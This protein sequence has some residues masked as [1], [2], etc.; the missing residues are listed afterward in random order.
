MKKIYTKQIQAAMWA[1]GLPCTDATY[2]NIMRS[3]LKSGMTEPQAFALTKQAFAAA[4][5]YT[6]EL[7]VGSL[8][9]AT[10]QQAN[11]AKSPFGKD[12]EDLRAAAEGRPSRWGQTDF[13]A[14]VS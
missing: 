13:H 10:T 1:L 12:A 5:G 4:K 8:I 9:H 6:W 11:A 7:P 2:A 3:L 14:G